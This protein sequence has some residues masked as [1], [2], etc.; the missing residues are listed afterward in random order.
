MHDLQLDI[1]DAPYEHYCRH[2]GLRAPLALMTDCEEC[3]GLSRDRMIPLPLRKPSGLK[4]EQSPP[5]RSNRGDRQAPHGVTEGL[6]LSTAPPELG[7]TRNGHGLGP[8]LTG[9]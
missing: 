9:G 4:R 6:T 7:A 5:C 1:T 2:L 3:A 8:G